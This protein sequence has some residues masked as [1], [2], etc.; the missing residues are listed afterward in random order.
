MADLASLQI[1]DRVA[2]PV[3]LVDIGESA[4]ATGEGNEKVK[5]YNKDPKAGSKAKNYLFG[6]ETRPY[7]EL[8]NTAN[9]A[10]TRILESGFSS[11]GMA[12]QGARP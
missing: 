5:W 7:Y 12:T 9:A 4:P 3:E 10:K 1:G 2:V 6:Y 8:E 11:M